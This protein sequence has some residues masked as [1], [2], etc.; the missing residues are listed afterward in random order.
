[1]DIVRYSIIADSTKEKYTSDLKL[2]ILDAEGLGLASISFDKPI[3]N[4]ITEL[5]LSMADGVAEFNTFDVNFYYNKFSIK[6]E[7][8]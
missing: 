7:L 1:M 8:D 4:S 5:N 2:R 6:I 3:M